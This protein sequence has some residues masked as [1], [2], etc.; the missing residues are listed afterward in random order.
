M[1][2][3]TANEQRDFLNLRTRPEVSDVEMQSLSVSP[4]VGSTFEVRVSQPFVANV[5]LATEQDQQV[6]AK[7][8]GHAIGTFN[9]NT[10]DD[11]ALEH[12]RMPVKVPSGI[13]TIRLLSYPS[14]L[15]DEATQDK[16]LPLPLS[17]SLKLQL[18]RD[19]SWR[20][21]ILDELPELSAAVI[22]NAL[23]AEEASEPS[24]PLPDSEAAIES[25]TEKPPLAESPSAG[26]EGE[27]ASPA[28][29]IND[30]EQ[31][32]APIEDDDDV[33]DIME[34]WGDEEGET[35]GAPTGELAGD[36]LMDRELDELAESMKED[37]NDIQPPSPEVSYSGDGESWREQ[38]LAGGLAEFAEGT[39]ESEEPELKSVP[40][41]DADEA[42]TPEPEPAADADTVT[43]METV[44]S[45]G[46]DKP[47]N[48]V[49]DVIL[50]NSEGPS[51]GLRNAL[52]H[53]KAGVIRELGGASEP[54]TYELYESGKGRLVL[55]EDARLIH[56]IP[57]E[58]H[59]LLFDLLGYGDEAKA[60]YESAGIECVRWID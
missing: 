1:T 12:C 40:K 39:T 24:K 35:D 54:V 59:S 33:N 34:D 3:A 42:V 21:I 53:G 20:E 22:Q 49:G 41:P 17:Q 60:L 31:P 26:E 19:L 15:H 13:P 14:N 28:E 32:S 38:P 57:E 50:D 11:W 47:E 55:H 5:T 48:G 36:G 51:V 8:T 9:K 6:V 18:S 46:A 29:A 7:V 58:D 43:T 23:D 27:Q 4:I 10:P 44:T 16:M 56:E 25:M 30:P 45:P 37:D 2:D 52:H